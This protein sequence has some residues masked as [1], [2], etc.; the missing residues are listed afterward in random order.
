MNGQLL[1]RG[2]ASVIVGGMD[3]DRA[4]L[5]CLVTVLLFTPHVGECG[6]FRYGEIAATQCPVEI[7][8][9]TYTVRTP[10]VFRCSWVFGPFMNTYAD[11]SLCEL[12]H[13]ETRHF[14]STRNGLFV[15]GN[16]AGDAY[17][18]GIFTYDINALRPPPA[19]GTT[20][21]L[22]DVHIVLASL[23]IKMSQSNDGLG[24]SLTH[25]T[26]T[27]PS[28]LSG[29]MYPTTQPTEIDNWLE[30]WN[31]TTG[32]GALTGLSRRELEA[33]VM[34]YGANASVAIPAAHFDTA[35]QS[36]VRLSGEKLRKIVRDAEEHP[37]MTPVHVTLL[38][39]CS[40]SVLRVPL[41]QPWDCYRPVG[42]ASRFVEFHGNGVELMATWR[43]VCIPPT[44]C[45]TPLECVQ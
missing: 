28:P 9:T 15:H 34:F 27:S 42:R 10:P 41:N 11:G 21:S 45:T 14:S 26:I 36:L 23:D 4:V 16:I 5:V 6:I 43:P 39:E 24:I 3:R 19:F 30:F 44:N 38:I 1:P 25:G 7:A 8:V 22:I 12:Y 37:S 17:R 40:S 18:H 20:W 31:E 2:N 32:A 35:A 33:N 29:I 13:N